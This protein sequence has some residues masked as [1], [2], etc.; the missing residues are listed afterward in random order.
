MKTI[1][2]AMTGASGAQYGLRLLEQLL[3]GGHRVYLM[4]SQAGQV[5]LNMETDLELSAR[6]R[7][8]QAQLCE[9]FDVTAEQLQVFGRDQWFAP[10]ASGS[11][12]PDA[13]VICPCT[14][15]TLGQIANGVGDTLLLRAAD[16]VIK[17]GRKL[18]LVVR[19]TPFSAIHLQNMLTL[20]QAGVV[21]MP[22][23]PGFYHQPR[24]I[25]DLVDYMVG[26][27]LDHLALPHR[28]G[29]RWGLDDE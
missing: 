23:N 6:P 29:P 2:I 3:S 26:R 15:S 12:A 21:I 11:G 9:H 24:G 17:E 25:A 20:A 13:M 22:A 8:M 16:V 1:A 14:T 7:E 4:V 28:I 18:I 5:V 19:E 10:V 27:V